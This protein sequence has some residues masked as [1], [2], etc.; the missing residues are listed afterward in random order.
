MTSRLIW[1][2]ELQGS[3][4]S[5][6]KKSDFLLPHYQNPKENGMNKKILSHL[7]VAGGLVLLLSLML[8][9]L[10]ASPAGNTAAPL[11]QTIWLRANAN[12]QYVSADQNLANV[13]LIANRAAPSGWEMFTVVDAG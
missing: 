11:G 4:A 2:G 6:K 7:R 10:A 12:S 13:Q 3:I 1:K 5:Y 9:L 8:G